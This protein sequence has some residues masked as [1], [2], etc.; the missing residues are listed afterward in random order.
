MIR[1]L[2]ILV[3]A[4]GTVSACGRTVVTPSRPDARF[5][6][7]PVAF[8][9]P[10]RLATS[11]EGS[12]EF[13]AGEQ[14]LF[15][16]RW[17]PGDE[18][19][20]TSCNKVDYHVGITCDDDACTWTAAGDGRFEVTPTKPGVLR[21]HVTFEPHGHQ[22]PVT[23]DLEPV[24]VVVP[25]SASAHC[26]LWGNGTAEV[27]VEL[28]ASNTAPSNTAPSNTALSH[29]ANVRL[30]GGPEC[31]RNEFPYADKRSA[32]SCPID[33]T[34]AELEVYTPGGYTVATTAACS[35][36]FPAPALGIQRPGSRYVFDL[37]D[38][39]MSCIDDLMRE[40]REAF[41]T[42]GWTEETRPEPGQS[43]FVASR[44]GTT[45]A[46]DLAEGRD[47]D[48]RRVCTWSLETDAT[49]IRGT[50]EIAE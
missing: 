22:K 13:T 18:H 9:T 21:A 31:S 16:A 41:A 11:W 3:T 10:I 8:G 1:E 15:A 29:D 43:R 27:D 39:Y 26:D 49:G 47:G 35:L 34:S 48:D 12:C 6:A 45:I 36:V 7:D 4:Y 14:A 37:R 42:W 46:V 20:T 28:Y 5:I 19:T 50:H 25:R 33:A 23:I 38:P 24:D 17:G 30:R 32:F 44:N 2:A 40:T